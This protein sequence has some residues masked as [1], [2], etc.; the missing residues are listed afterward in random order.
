MLLAA[1]AGGDEPPQDEAKLSPGPAIDPGA[2][3]EPSDSGS[4]GPRSFRLG[5]TPDDLLG[6][7]RGQRDGPRD[8]GQACRPRRVPHREW[9]PLGGG[10]RREALPPGRGTAPGQVVPIE[11]PSTRRSG[12][13]SRRDPAQDVAERPRGLLGRRRGGREEMEG[14]EA[15]RPGDDPR[16]YALLPAHDRQVQARL[17]RLRDRGQHVGGGQHPKVRSS[18]KS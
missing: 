11:G 13:L 16:L 8:A 7:A 12:R 18:F 6:D 14:P 9:G 10:P 4:P 2:G 15:R 5:F 17:L 1:P 3:R